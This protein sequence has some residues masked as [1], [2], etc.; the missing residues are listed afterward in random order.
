MLKAE[1]EIS[2]FSFS[3][4]RF[5]ARIVLRENGKLLTIVHN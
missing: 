5:P 3:D 2:V 1:R 4:F